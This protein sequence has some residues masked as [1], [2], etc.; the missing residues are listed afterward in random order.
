MRKS[1]LFVLL[2]LA[3]VFGLSAQAPQ[4]TQ[5]SKP[6]DILKNLVL[7]EKAAP[8][9]ENMKPGFE[10]I[11]AKDSKVL[12]TYLSSDLLEGRETATRGYELAAEY[13]ASL[14]ALWKLKPAG[15][16]PV[17]ERRPT[18]FADA[19]APPQLEK[20]FTQEFIL[21]EILESLTQIALEVRLG[22]LVKSRT[23]QSGIDF[24]SRAS[25]A[26]SLSAPVVFGGYGITEKGIGWDEFKNVE[27]KGKIVLILSEAP[28][29]DDPKSP[30]WQNKELKEKYFPAAPM[31]AITRGGGSA[32]VREISKLQ[33]AAILQVQNTGQ[34]VD[35]FKNLA[36]PA[37]LSDDRPFPPERRRLT[38]PGVA[39][40]MPWEST[41][42][43]TITREMADALL[44]ASGQKIDDLK[45][46]IESTAK[47]ASLEIPGTRLTLSTTL[48]T[49]LVRG[50]NVLGYVEG[51]D[52]VLKNEVVVVGAHLDHLGRRGDYIFNGADDNG[53][54]SVGILNLARAFAL[55][56]AKPKRSVLFCLWTGEEE[57][58]LGSRFYVLNPAFPLDKTVAY[59]NLDMISRPYD[60]K[61][62]TRMGRWMGL[63]AVQEL[64]KKIKPANFLPISFTSGAGLAEALRAADQSVGLDIFLRESSPS[65]DRDSGGSD[66][67]SF[68][69]A[70]IPW[71]FAIAAMT[72][73]YHQTSDSVEKT[74]PE[75][76]E[77]IS[78]LIYLTVFTLADR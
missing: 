27:V 38:L 59:L 30:F 7:V 31:V 43:I 56:P 35:L 46:K 2:I 68:G 15:D 10:S 73:D 41:P 77:K 48:K 24:Q 20:R 17:I 44:E 57:G 6:E 58:L 40:R 36:G 54:G 51:S 9:Q 33:P 1:V 32:K 25:E 78:R 16:A 47:P 76:M 45:K 61:T 49:A 67:S 66:H 65:P 26:V 37:R 22:S 5:A 34:D 39:A 28:G 21:K 3:L 4:Q 52:P 74:S 29:K 42:V 72:E 70:K 62:L 19:G 12:L 55:N 71:L 50:Q 14:F 69:A 18:S 53:S 11:T 63:P 60:E 8:P 75:L 64:T 13:A 23:F